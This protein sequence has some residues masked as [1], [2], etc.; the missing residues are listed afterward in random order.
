MSS[1]GLMEIN[2]LPRRERVGYAFKAAA[3]ALLICAVLGPAW[4]GI[5][6]YTVTH[7]LTRVQQEL[8][9]TKK[10]N[11]AK[12]KNIVQGNVGSV[13]N[14]LSALIPVVEQVPVSAVG[15]LNRL[16]ALLPE[17]GFV[18][19]YQYNEEAVT[20]TVQFETMLETSA[21]LNR[22]NHAEWVESVVMPGVATGGEETEGTDSTPEMPTY[23]T[24]FQIKLNKQAIKDLEGQ[25]K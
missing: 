10:L 7:S 24:T 25:A 20:M 12:E 19:D 21:Y 4:L 6:Y 14:G 22:L 15:I 5:Q 8:D 11:A 3:T 18:M 17:R 2:L 23:S 1:T 16:V 9:M 13:A